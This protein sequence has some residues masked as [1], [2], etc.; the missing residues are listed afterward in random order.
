M[1]GRD[2]LRNAAMVAPAVFDP[3]RRAIVCVLHGPRSP[4]RPRNTGS[5]YHVSKGPPSKCPFK[6]PKTDSVAHLRNSR[7]AR[8][9]QLQRM[10]AIGGSLPLAPGVS[11]V[12]YPIP[13]RI[14]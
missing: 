10:A 13:E 11:T 3:P 12:R 7:E 9:S 5:V 2:I 6:G 4:L 14:F 1:P 8:R